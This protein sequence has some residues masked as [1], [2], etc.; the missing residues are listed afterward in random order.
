MKVAPAHTKTVPTNENRVKGSDS[1]SVAQIELNTR[2]D[3]CSGDSRTTGNVVIWML[4]P[5]MF[6]TMN[7]SIP[8]Y[9]KAELARVRST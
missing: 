4:E 6:E 1:I 8:I 5:K 9:S 3:A 2:P 7:N